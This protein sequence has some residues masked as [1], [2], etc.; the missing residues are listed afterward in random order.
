MN[1]N[2]VY[3]LMLSIILSSCDWQRLKKCEWYLI[4]DTDNVE[5]ANEGF[6]TIC[7]K[8]YNIG[9]KKCYLELEY[10]KAVAVYKKTI[11]YSTMEI[12]YSVYPRRILSYEVCQKEGED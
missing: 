4:P 1:L 9:R 7:V 6:V 5:I 11:R 2:A 10:D 3:I 12:D 8:N